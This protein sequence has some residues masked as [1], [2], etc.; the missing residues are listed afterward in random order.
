[1][2][3]CS[4][5]VYFADTLQILISNVCGHGEDE[6]H[7]MQML[8]GH[9]FNFKKIRGCGADVGK[10]LRLW[11]RHGFDS[12]KIRGCGADMVKILRMRCKHGILDV[13]HTSHHGHFHFVTRISWGQLGLISDQQESVIRVMCRVEN[14]PTQL[15]LEFSGVSRFWCRQ[16]RSCSDCLIRVRFLACAKGVNL[17]VGLQKWNCPRGHCHYVYNGFCNCYNH[18]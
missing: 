1:M 17:T 15:L 3:V 8:C 16:L 10:I 6:V 11:C 12:L 7:I 4:Y 13:T 2:V 18:I 5:L 9:R 14:H